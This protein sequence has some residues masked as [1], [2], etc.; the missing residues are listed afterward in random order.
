MATTIRDNNTEENLYNILQKNALEQIQL[1]S[2][3]IWTDYNPHDPGITILD[4]LNYVLWE[5]NYQLSFDLEDYLTPQNDSFDPELHGLF[6]SGK[7][8]RSFPVTPDDYRELILRHFEKLK[9]VHVIPHI[10]IHEKEDDLCGSYDIWIQLSAWV[11]ENYTSYK[12]IRDEVYK[13]YH[14]NRNLCESLHETKFTNWEKLDLTGELEIKTSAD[15][16]ELLASVYIEAR[17]L[18]DNP[19]SRPAFFVPELYKRLKSNTAILSIRSLD[20]LPLNSK[21]DVYTTIRLPKEEKDIKIVLKNGENT[22]PIDFAQVEKRL[23][24]YRMNVEVNFVPE[25]ENLVE[26]SIPRGTYRPIYNYY[27]VQHDFPDCYG[28]NIWGVAASASDRRKAQA[29]QLKAYLLLFDLLFGKGLKEAEDMPQWMTLASLLPQNEIPVL[30]KDPILQWEVLTDPDEFGKIKKSQKSSLT[31]E[32]SKWLDVLDKLYGEN[33]NPEFL[34]RFN[35]YYHSEEETIK[36]RVK[37]LSGVPFWG[38]N[39]FKGINITDPSPAGRSGLETYISTLL[40]F[41]S[42]PGHPVSNL[43][44]SYNLK[45]MDDKRFFDRFNQLLEYNL[46][47]PAETTP[48]SSPFMQSIVPDIHWSDDEY[49][50]LRQKIP[51]LSLGFL[52]ESFLHDGTKLENYK[53]FSI[54]GD[55]SKLLLFYYPK[56]QEWKS[57]GRFTSDKEI[58]EIANLLCGFMLMLNKRSEV[59]YVVE[60]LLLPLSP[61]K[62]LQQDFSLTSVLSGSSIRMANPLFRREVE[63]VI[64]NRTA[65][66]LNITFLWLSLEDIVKFEHLYFTWRQMLATSDTAKINVASDKLAQYLTTL[67]ESV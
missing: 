38:L 29:R 8:F 32:K 9:D 57:L 5:L 33:S 17:N 54:M 13:L 59:M 26:E 52:F 16:S 66:H 39:R 25:T 34:N 27:S 20:L 24:Q 62:K 51:F 47:F 64:R 19:S 18:M 55:G 44:A 40:G 48:A 35:Y 61:E 15:P 46:I 31:K 1:L 56:T 63:K 45:V 28:I 2:G 36:R 23:Y 43:F 22:I 4:L 21:L 60:H 41:G 42:P 12:N 3:N 6:K 10:P 50:R 65:L 49:D 14:Q 53:K 67:K 58:N 30:D 7:V 11:D 37:F